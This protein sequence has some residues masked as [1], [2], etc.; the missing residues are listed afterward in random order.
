[1]DN[2]AKM[3]TQL[4]GMLTDDKQDTYEKDKKPIEKGSFGEVFRGAK[5]KTGKHVVGLT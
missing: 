5:R 4:E 3:G 2:I 1:M